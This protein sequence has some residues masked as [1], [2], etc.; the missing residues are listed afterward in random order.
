ME[1]GS[2]GRWV[3]S[4]PLFRVPCSGVRAALLASG[5]VWLL[6]PS[7]VLATTLKQGEFSGNHHLFFDILSF[8][9]KYVLYTT[10]KLLYRSVSMGIL[11]TYLS[12]YP[13]NRPELFVCLWCEFGLVFGFFFF[14]ATENCLLFHLP[15]DGTPL[16][17]VITIRALWLFL[18]FPLRQ[19]LPLT[20]E[21]PFDITRMLYN[22]LNGRIKIKFQPNSTV[23][24]NCLTWSGRK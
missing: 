13:Q 6:V 2:S 11:E 14:L 7:L 1:S 10:G 3:L 18:E 4:P 17:L 19:K 8:P 23:V 22:K 5:G 24:L 12:C 16:W 21:R 9:L 15:L 20:A